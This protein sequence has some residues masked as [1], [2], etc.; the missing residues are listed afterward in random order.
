MTTGHELSQV[1]DRSHAAVGRFAAGDP[2]PLIALHSRSDDVTIANPF[3]P[4]VRGL[5]R[6]HHRAASAGVGDRS[7]GEGREIAGARSGKTP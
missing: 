3:G 6:P 1:I 5:C 2:E 7:L 4:L